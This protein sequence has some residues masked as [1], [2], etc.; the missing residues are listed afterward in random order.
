MIE[1]IDKYEVTK[2]FKIRLVKSK[3]FKTDLIGLFLLRPLSDKEASQMALISRLLSR[4]TMGYPNAKSFNDRLDDLYGAIFISDTVKYGERIAMHCKIQFPNKRLIENKDIYKDAAMFLRNALFDVYHEGDRFNQEFFDQEKNK[5]IEEINSR[6]N[7]KITYAVERCIETMC[8]DEAFS[9]YQ[10]GSVDTIQS[11]T[12][13]E[14]YAYYLEFL[15]SSPM[16]ILSIGDIDPDETYE[17]IEKT[18]DIKNQ[19]EVVDTE[20]QKVIYEKR[21][22]KH[23]TENMNV[24]QGKLTLGFRTN[25]RYDDPLYEPAVL[26]ATILGGGGNSTLF[27]NVREKESL[28]YY[29]FSKIEKFK[30]IMLIAAGIEVENYEKTLKLILEEIEKLKIGE[31]TED[32]INIAKEVIVSS[33][34]SLVDYPNSFINYY[35]SRELTGFE[36]DEKKMIEDIMKVTKEEIIEAGNTLILDT[37]HFIRG[38]K[39][40]DN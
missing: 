22:A 13:E 29:I 39:Q 21:D 11:L 26:F 4:G 33:V 23:I 34:R 18:F 3:K 27:R 6:V 5:L 8:E 16:E 40:N 1:S 24:N 25:I 2:D 36:Y 20:C 38:D 31:F 17:L 37:V 32:D 19:N 12:N 9:V 14:V 28:C 7:D 10:Y 30:S 35:Y 15:T